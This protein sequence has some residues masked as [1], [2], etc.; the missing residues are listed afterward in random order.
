MFVKPSQTVVVNL[1]LAVYES[2]LTV[3]DTKSPLPPS[4]EKE[5]TD[6]SSYS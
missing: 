5:E 4:S 6:N 2:S 3:V 1:R